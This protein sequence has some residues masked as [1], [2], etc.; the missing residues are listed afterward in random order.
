[1]LNLC[2]ASKMNVSRWIEEVITDSLA[3]TA[4]VTPKW[5]MTNPTSSWVLCVS[6]AAPSF[7]S[8]HQALF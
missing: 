4:A 1:M 5:F 2:N 6:A 3:E 7:S 8:L